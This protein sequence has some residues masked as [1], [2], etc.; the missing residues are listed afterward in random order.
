M[1]GVGSKMLARVVAMRIQE[2]TETWLHES[3]NGFR[4]GRGVDDA[5]QGSRRLVEEAVRST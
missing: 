3:N 2:W 1:L 5:L 4:R